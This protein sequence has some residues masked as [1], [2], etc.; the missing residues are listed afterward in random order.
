VRSLA[1][2][3]Q[4]PSGRWNLSVPWYGTRAPPWTLRSCPRSRPTFSSTLWHGR[5]VLA[6][7][8]G[9][10]LRTH[11]RPHIP[12]GIRADH[13]FETVVTSLDVG[14]RKPHPVIYE[15]HSTRSALARRC[16]LRRR[17]CLADYVGPERSGIRAFLIDPE[18][19][20]DVPG[21]RRIDSLFRLAGHLD[22][23][24]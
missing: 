10:G 14:R 21:T 16:P 5:Q 2:R 24:T 18:C 1:T 11:A 22:E 17:T 8:H 23:Q 7:P 13:F 19:I 20:D 3:R 4:C 12:E 6:L 15:T 9:P